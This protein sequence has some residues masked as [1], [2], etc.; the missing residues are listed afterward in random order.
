MN[1]SKVNTI[2]QMFNMLKKNNSVFTALANYSG[3]DYLSKCGEIHP[4]DCMIKL[5]TINNYDINLLVLPPDSYYYNSVTSYI[6]ILKGATYIELDINQK[7]NPGFI[8]SND[9]AL[10]LCNPHTFSNKSMGTNI[11]LT[12]NKTNNSNYLP[13]L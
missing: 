9:M 11:L 8:I 2:P 13:L 4:N 3:R 12:A 5:D 1:M 10:K 6:R 7:I